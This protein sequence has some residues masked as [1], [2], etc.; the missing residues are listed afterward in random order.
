MGGIETV[1][2]REN[3]LYYEVLLNTWATFVYFFSQWLLTVLVTRFSGYE[4][5]GTFTL[6]VSF[7][8]I[9]GYI[10]KFGMRS[11]QVG[12]IQRKY[13]DSQYFVSRI[14]TSV[15]C[16]VPFIVTLT[17]CQYRKD[18]HY[19][20]IAMMVYKLLEGFDDV[21]MGSFQ[22]LHRYREIAISYTA[23]AILTLGAF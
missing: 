1:K 19:C 21:I 6:A 12:D 22:R 2:H 4:D 10:S 16:I 23:K 20:C 7:S 3:N 15:A 5:A 9:F 14:I 13:S 18:L 11:L 8:N 17:F